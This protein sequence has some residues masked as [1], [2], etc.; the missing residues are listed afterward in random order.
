MTTNQLDM[1][2]DAM[3]LRDNGPSTPIDHQQQQQH[4]PQHQRRYSQYGS[5]RG[6]SSP[7]TR[8]GTFGGGN[9]NGN[10]SGNTT[11]GYHSQRNS[12]GMNGGSQSMNGKRQ[13]NRMSLASV[14]SLFI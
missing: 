5:E 7:L 4:Q 3:S 2:F 10:G 11:P 8:K 1:S 14:V 12:V 6:S 9:G 13:S